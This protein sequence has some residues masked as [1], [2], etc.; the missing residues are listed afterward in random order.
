MDK[1]PQQGSE[2]VLIYHTLH[3]AFEEKILEMQDE[4]NFQELINIIK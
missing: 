4:N 1:C 2:T 3:L